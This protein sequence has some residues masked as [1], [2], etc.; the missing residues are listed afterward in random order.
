MIEPF[1]Q[2]R[3]TVISPRA[4]HHRGECSPEFNHAPTEF[5]EILRL[6]QGDVLLVHIAVFFLLRPEAEWGSE[7]HG[8]AAFQKPIQQLPA[9]CL[10]HVLDD[11]AD[12]ADVEVSKCFDQAQSIAYMHLVVHGIPH[13]ISIVLEDLNS[14]DADLPFFPAKATLPCFQILAR[15]YPP[16]AE[17]HTDIEDRLRL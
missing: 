8:V 1:L 6:P 7:D 16:F 5:L 4:A 11:V 17:A 14:F 2:S 9:C 12:K 10:V 13:G 15:N 3:L